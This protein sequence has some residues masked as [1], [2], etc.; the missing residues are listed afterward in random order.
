MRLFCWS[1]TPVSG[2]PFFASKI[3]SQHGLEDVLLNGHGIYLFKFNNING[4]QHVIDNGPWTIKNGP[5]FVQKW[6]SGLNL[7]SAKHDK[8]PL[9]VKI[10]DISYDASND[11]G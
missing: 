8:I 9:W 2:C 3:W 10:H 11:E 7:N 6:R 4:L 5:I 1:K